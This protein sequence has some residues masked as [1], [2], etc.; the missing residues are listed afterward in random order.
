MDLS[1]DAWLGG[2]VGPARGIGKDFFAREARRA[3]LV[4][5][6]RTESADVGL[7]SDWRELAAPDFDPAAVHPSV[8]EFYVE[9]SA[10]DLDAW[11]EWRG[12]FRPF[13][14][15]LARLFSRRLQQLNVPLSALDTS[16]GVTSE[17]V[18]FVDPS[19]GGVREPAWVRELVGSGNVL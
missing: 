9:T 5:R 13:G 10:F 18:Q 1:A 8:I 16:R 12:V 6:S 17:V 3:G 2:P 14:W 15:L 4:A 19:S 11:S 7:V